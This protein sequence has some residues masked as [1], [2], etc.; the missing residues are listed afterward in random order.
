M[1][2]AT[3]VDRIEDVAAVLRAHNIEAII[4]E[5]GDAPHAR[6]SS[7]A[8]PRAPRS[9]GANPGHSRTSASS[10][11]LT[12]PGR[13]DALRPRLSTMDRAT[14]GAA[15]CASWCRRRTTCWAASRR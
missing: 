3:V 2:A 8:Y 10:K 6:A 4:V 13:F 5:T 9:T 12:E 11:R 15:R 14:Q 1:K 7:V